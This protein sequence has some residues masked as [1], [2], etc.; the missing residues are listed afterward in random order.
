MKLALYDFDETL[1]HKNSL[2]CLI[3]NAVKSKPELVVQMGIKSIFSPF[4]RNGLERDREWDA[5]SFGNHSKRVFRQQLYLALARHFD[6]D[7]LYGFGQEAARRLKVNQNVVDMMIQYDRKGHETWIVTGSIEP[8]VQGVV[9]HYGWPVSRVVGTL[10]EPGR[11]GT[12][13]FKECL[14]HEKVKRITAQMG[15]LPKHGWEMVAFGNLPDDGPMLDLATTSF[16]VSRGKPSLL[17]N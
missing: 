7:D 10:W 2:W 8:F 1:T 4:L 15:C 12:R 13:T 9:D 14:R 3:Q 17:L 11:V 16:S 5:P 6:E